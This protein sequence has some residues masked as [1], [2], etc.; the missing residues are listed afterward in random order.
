MSSFRAASPSVA[1]SLMAVRI[2]PGAMA[3]IRIRLGA[4]SWAKLRIIIATPPLEA[5]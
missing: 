1:S 5:A 3:L 2:A 4:T